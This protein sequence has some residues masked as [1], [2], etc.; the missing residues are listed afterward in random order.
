M[1]K[2]TNLN[3]RQFLNVGSKLVLTLPVAYAFGCASDKTLLPNP[4]DSLKKLIFLLGPWSTSEKEKAN[5]FAKRFL[6]SKPATAP[7]LPESE[8]LVQSLAKHFPA[9]SMAIHQINLQT[10]QAKE[11]ELLV[12]LTKQIYSYVEVRFY[13]ANEPLWGHCQGDRLWHTRSPVPSVK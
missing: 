8:K 12:T 11:R 6:K 5:D 4:E 9:E 3:R 10:I 7:Y 1:K 2:N 13:V